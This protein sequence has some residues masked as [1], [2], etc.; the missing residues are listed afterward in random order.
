MFSEVS[1]RGQIRRGQNV[2]GQRAGVLAR[3]LQD[4]YGDLYFTFYSSSKNVD[5]FVAARAH[6]FNRING[7]YDQRT[8]HSTSI[9]YEQQNSTNFNKR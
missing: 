3:E 2:L 8:N 6:E 1:L 9:T 4:P 5:D 7:F